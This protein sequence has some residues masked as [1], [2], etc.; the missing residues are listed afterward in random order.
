[1]DSAEDRDVPVVVIQHTF[2]APDKPFF[3]K[4]TDGWQLHPE[5][6]ARPRS[7]LIEKTLPGSFTGTDLEALAPRPR[8]RH[9]VGLRLHDA[10]VLRHHRAPGG[11]PGLP[12]RVPQRRDRDAAGEELGRR[13]DRR[14]AAPLDPLRRSR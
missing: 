11:P 6:A 3:R 10:Y 4:G 8:D 13:G 9:G 5:V 1:M 7:H 12:R 14:G 2:T